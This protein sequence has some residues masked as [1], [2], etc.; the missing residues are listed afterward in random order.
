MDARAHRRL[1]PLTPRVVEQLVD[2]RV[3]AEL[4][5][6]H[7][8]PVLDRQHLRDERRV[9]PVDGEGHHADPVVVG[10]FIPPRIGRRLN[11]LGKREVFETPVLGWLARHG[12]IHAVERSAVDLE[13]FRL[14]QRILAAGHP[15]AVFPEGT[16]SPDGAL[17]EV[18]DGL[19]L[20]AQRTGVPIV[21]VA[22]VD[23]VVDARGS[24]DLAKAYLDFLFTPEAQEIAAQNFHRVHDQ[25]V[26]AKHAD[27]FPE[28]RLVTVEDAFGGWDK[29]AK[30]HFADGGLL[31]KVFVNQ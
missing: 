8:D 1:G 29:V 24:R 13:A 4:P 14:A 18:K 15:L 23:K 26:A 22:I 6:A 11:W 12:G 9:E 7:T 2:Q 20:L 21:P 31:D 28:V 5:V 3:R 30:D 19:A 25:T 10:A 27:T 16:R 17:R